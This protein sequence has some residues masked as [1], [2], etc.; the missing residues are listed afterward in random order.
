[1]GSGDIYCRNRWLQCEMTNLLSQRWNSLNDERFK[2]DAWEW[3]AEV[4]SE[5]EINITRGECQKSR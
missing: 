2:K 3:V 4:E 1:M 5:V